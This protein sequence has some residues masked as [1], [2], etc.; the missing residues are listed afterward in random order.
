MTHARQ[1][2]PKSLYA[3]TAIPAVET[4]PL[5]GERSA[6]VAIVGGGFTGLSTALHLAEKGI[7]P[8][9]LEANEPGWGA[10]GRNGGQVNPGLYPDPSGILAAFGQER[11]QRALS[12]S[13]DAPNVVFR[14]IE[15]QQIQCEAAQ[16]GTL[17]VAYNQEGLA[18][19]KETFTQLQASGSP[20]MWRDADAL[21]AATGTNRYVG[22][23][24]FPQG[25]KVN[26][27]GYARGLAKA[28]INLGA[29][30]HGGS[31]ATRIERQGTRWKVTTPGGSVTADRLVLATNGYSDGLWPDLA[32]SIVPLFSTI[33]AT[34]PLPPEVAAEVMPSGS[35]LYE[36]G[37]VTVYYRLDAGGRLLMG[38][39]ARQ[40]PLE[41][42]ADARHLI[43]YA[44]RLFPQLNGRQ[45]THAWNGQLAITPDYFIHVHEPAENVHVCLGYNGRGVAMATAMGMALAER[46]AGGRAEDLPIPVTGIRP[47]PFHAFW[48]TGVDLRILYGRIRDRL[49]L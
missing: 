43:D 1:P 47:M 36:A 26:P 41:D 30:V 2:L 49:G 42:I 24:L 6:D 46:V 19:T 37:H 16:T 34:E 35:V 3:D 8:I 5:S 13:S 17:R 44:H 38:G 33:A 18:R 10:S 12:F 22:G 27:L 40:R 15:R 7:R 11:G 4:P 45:W 14:L 20:V 31:P 23:M 48:K 28:A 25:G 21:A 9:V 32:R 29:V 39:R